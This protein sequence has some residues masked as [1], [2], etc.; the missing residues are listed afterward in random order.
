[1]DWLGILEQV[2]EIILFPALSAA[3]IFFITWLNA[4]TKELSQ[5]TDNELAKKYIEL[6]DTT[7]TE[8]VLATKQTYVEALKKEGKFDLEAQK[9]AF[10]QT[11]DAV[12]AILSNEAQEYINESVNDI[13]AY[14][15]NKIE[16]QVNNIK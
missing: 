2:F 8:C 14:I 6:L 13:G 12:L 9:K 11:Y 5:K 15:T 16:A 4:K 10:Q 1:M 3:A 7:I